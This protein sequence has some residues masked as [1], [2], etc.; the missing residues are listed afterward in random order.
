[1]QPVC[2]ND[3]CGRRICNVSLRGA[4]RTNHYCS[5]WCRDEGEQ[6]RRGVVY[7]AETRRSGYRPLRAYPK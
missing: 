7:T 3:T 5:E 1:M 6:K 4:N 2:D